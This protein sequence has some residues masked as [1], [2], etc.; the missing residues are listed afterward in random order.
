MVMTEEKLEVANIIKDKIDKLD[1]EIDDLMDIMPPV[2]REFVKKNRRGPFR[3]IK[4]TGI[5]LKDEGI[6]IE[7]SNEDVRA[8]VDIR[9][10]EQEALRQVLE[11]I[12]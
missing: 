7:L 11:E 5:T 3:K 10:S 2:R 9:T 8:L 1:K 4:R 12:K 6:E